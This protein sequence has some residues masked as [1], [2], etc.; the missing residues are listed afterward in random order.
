M[1]RPASRVFFAAST[2]L[3]TLVLAMRIAAADVVPSTTNTPLAE[4]TVTGDTQT[5]AAPS[6]NAP[7]ASGAS[8]TATEKPGESSAKSDRDAGRSSRSERRRDRTERS[9]TAATSSSSPSA[10]GNGTDYPSFQ[11]IPERNIFNVNRSSRASRAARESEPKP[12]KV[13]TLALVGSM[14]YPKGDFAFFDGSSSDFRRVIK[15]GDSIAGFQLRSIG[16]NSVQLESAG[17]T[18]ELAIGSH[19]RREEEGEW[20]VVAETAPSSNASSSGSSRRSRSDGE[21]TNSGAS[22]STAQASESSGGSADDILQRLMKKRE[23][24]L[25]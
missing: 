19:L 10:A 5:A 20:R 15:A 25:K 13:D 16:R 21:S 4:T 9:S 2:L 22:T 3:A 11:I 24:E 7:A 23:T 18:V 1:N 17:K 8:S 6:T 12:V 14:S